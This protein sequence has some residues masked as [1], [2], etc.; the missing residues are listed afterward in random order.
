MEE[1]GSTKGS[2]SYARGLGAGANVLKDQGLL[3]RVQTFAGTAFRVL[4]EEG[5]LLGGGEVLLCGLHAW[6]SRVVIPG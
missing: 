3:G 4:G 1:L 5:H 2:F 6:I